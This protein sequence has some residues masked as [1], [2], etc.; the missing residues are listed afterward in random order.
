MVAVRLEYLAFY[1]FVAQQIYS[2]QEQAPSELHQSVRFLPRKLGCRLAKCERDEL[3]EKDICR[4]EL[5]PRHSSAQEVEL[6]QLD[7]CSIL[8]LLGIHFLPQDKAKIFDSL[9]NAALA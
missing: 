8:E 1:S 5:F 2:V 3:W 4:H 7:F 6:H 9:I